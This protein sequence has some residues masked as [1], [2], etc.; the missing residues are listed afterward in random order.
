M[1]LVHLF[2]VLEWLGLL[3]FP[4]SGRHGL[5][6]LAFMAFG[7]ENLLDSELFDGVRSF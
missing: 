7:D 4:W 6:G 2:G 5:G 3:I 1:G